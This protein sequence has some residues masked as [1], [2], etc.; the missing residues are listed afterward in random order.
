MSRHIMSRHVGHVSDVA[1]VMSCHVGYACYYVLLVMSCWSY[2]VILIRPCCVMSCQSRNAGHI[3]S[4]YFDHVVF[5]L[6]G[7]VIYVMLS[8]VM[9]ITSCHVGHV[10]L[11]NVMSVTSCHVNHVMSRYVISCR[12][13]H[14]HFKSCH[15]I[16]CQHVM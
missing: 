11:C 13:C 12:L 1:H 15:I 5:Y 14:S 2:R 16:S 6:I 4:S 9:L 7:H 3:M 10:L 8:N